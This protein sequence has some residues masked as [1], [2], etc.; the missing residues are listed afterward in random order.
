M[1]NFQPPLPLSLYI[2]LPWCIKKCPYCD[3]NSHAK[4]NI[5]DLEDAYIDALIKDLESQLACIFGRPISSIFLGGGTPS[6]FSAQAIEKLMQAL[7]KKLIL[8]YNA[9]ITIEANPGTAD[10]EKFY[11]YRQSGINRI[12]IGIQSFSDE[13]LKSLGRMH[14]SDQAIK[15]VAIAKDA[16]FEKINIDLMYGLPDQTIAQVISDLEIAW[17]QDISH[18]SWYQL[19]IEPNT[20]FYT[21]RPDLPNDDLIWEMQKQGQNFLSTKNF[22]QYEISAYAKTDQENISHQCRHNLNYWEFGDYL[23]IGAGAHSKLT[24]LATGSVRR[25]VRHR[26]PQSYMAK[27]N[28]ISEEKLLSTAELPLEFMMNS[29]RLK[30]GFHP[31]LFTERTGMALH[32]IQHCLEKAQKKAYISYDKKCIKPT[33]YGYQYLNEVLQ[34]FM[35]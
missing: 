31:M 18:L 11:A 10:I 21:N 16:G 12:S 9:E 8:F 35:P 4:N 3:F 22:E 15:A 6:L 19:T 24:N 20:F 26:I 34:S 7:R 29:L 32:Q 27:E 23:G 2:H 30:H 33:E 13:K 5:N 28:A 14:N 1:L 17:Q 25:Y